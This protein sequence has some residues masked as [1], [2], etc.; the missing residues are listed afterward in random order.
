LTISS[1]FDIILIEN[2]V[3]LVKKGGF[4]KIFDSDFNEVA[5]RIL[6]QRFIKEGFHVRPEEAKREIIN[7]SK[8]I[9][10][11]VEK[12]AEAYKIMM[13]YLVGFTTA[14]INEIKTDKVEK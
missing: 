2:N 12:T 1:Y 6:V 14:K 7:I 4:M 11:P 8:S 5:A 13:D 9:G 3:V 10:V